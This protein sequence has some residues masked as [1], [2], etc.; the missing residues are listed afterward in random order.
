VTTRRRCCSRLC[1]QASPSSCSANTAAVRGLRPVGARLPACDIARQVGRQDVPR[2]LLPPERLLGL[3]SG[4]VR[5]DA[6]AFDDP[7]G[8]R[9]R[10]KAAHDALHGVQAV[11]ERLNLRCG[12]VPALNGACSQLRRRPDTQ[13][14]RVRA[15]VI[16]HHHRAVG[17]ERHWR[18]AG[19]RRRGAR[20]ALASHVQGCQFVT[21]N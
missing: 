4:Q 8:A 1:W 13:P 20:P 21:T 19:R 3:H 7:A 9:Q 18:A 11:R 15:Q 6:A 10:T 17:P 14:L 2:E 16:Q 12:L 5:G